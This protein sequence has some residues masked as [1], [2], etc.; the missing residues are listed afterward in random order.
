[1]LANQRILRKEVK[2]MKYEKP[3]INVVA[4]AVDA[5]KISTRK[6]QIHADSTVGTQGPPAYEA[7]E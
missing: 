4:W 3:E 1:L 5:V 6:P 7:D 2:A